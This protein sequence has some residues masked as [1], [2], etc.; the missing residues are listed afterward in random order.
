MSR[1]KTTIKITGMHCAVCGQTIEKALKRQTGVISANVNFATE[2]AS[3]EFD[4]DKIDVEKLE[5]TV[6]GT[7]YGVFEEE[8]EV[9]LKVS[10]MES[11]HCA[12]IVEKALRN[13]QGIQK[14]KLDF[15]S[16]RAEVRYNPDKITL[17]A[18]KD[19]IKKTGYECV[20]LKEAESIDREKLAREK[21]IRELR[22]KLIFGA[23]LS[24]VIFLGSFTELFPWVPEFLQNH[25]TLFILATPVQFWVGLQFY[26]GA[27][28]ALKNKTT[29]MNTLIAVGSSAAYLYSAAVALFPSFFISRGIGTSIYF[30]T[31]AFIIT[32][33]ILGRYFE[34]LARGRTSEAIKNL[35][36]LR[37]KTALVLRDGK[38]V[39]I[40]AEDVQ[41]GDLLVVRPGEK[42]PVDGVVTAGYSGVDEK[43]ITGESIPVE[44][45]K[46]D[47]V[48]GATIN[49]TG[50]LK[51]K[52]T[53]VGKDTV[54]A[55]IIRIVEEAQ[56]S[57]APIQRMADLIASYFVPSVI[58]IAV[59]SFLTWYFLVGMSFLFTLTIFIA[60][61]IIACP[62]AMGLATPTAIMVGTG[63]GAENGILIKSGEA[64]ERAH[65]IQSV[66]FDKTGTLTKGEPSVTDIITLGSTE[67]DVL[68]L[69]AIAEKGS[70]HPIGEAIVRGA[71]VQK[72]EI[73]D[74]SG[75]ETVAGKGIRAMY[76]NQKILV[77]NRTFMK[78][79]KID[80]GPLENQ[81]KKLEEAG[82]TSVIVAVN[83]KVLGMIAVA[84]TITE[85][86]KE[87][88][89]ELHRMK[90]EVI[91]IT[92]D[93]EM[94][95]KA[96][97]GQLGI[98]RVLAQVL[99]G[100]K[101]KEIKKLQEEGKVVA[102]VG[103]GINDAPALTQADVGI[104]IGSGTDIA[105]ESGNIVLIKNDVRDVV[106]AIDLSK[107]TI[108]KIRQN[109][110]WAFF[111]NSA[112]I[113]IAAGILYPFFN[114]LLSPVIA[115]GVMA[116]SSV[117]VVG[118]SLLMKRY[119]S[120]I[121]QGGM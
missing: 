50:L 74:A 104:A 100:E 105:M 86:A 91:M 89:E 101:A 64:L 37:A 42:I 35:V 52:A 72:I 39:E 98:D 22:I 44:K 109:L 103:D 69:A 61:L 112:G 20:E 46:G 117:S 73:P 59:A 9:L 116:F 25:T 4:P 87:A 84:D 53:N 62:C 3:V 8:G 38:E 47:K 14:V 33:I 78:E 43:V 99:P 55:Q 76:S 119:K 120:K 29:D 60:V 13:T 110:F 41:V 6:R 92:G 40:P 45:R 115:A 114:F 68:K 15:S 83:Q 57:K 106:T 97:A 121:G 19:A 31:A 67:K 12:E 82:K 77:G 85:Y 2:K 56:A 30:D 5:D 65:K 49:K 66:V 51:F 63:K 90:K 1:K 48:I 88:V 36:G 95:A 118:N 111:Y 10:G 96:I 16:E 94:T 80:Y 18:I 70:E 93:N 21:Q 28:I 17:Q 26:R 11:P 75:Y 27:W 79:N 102:M 58:L 113:P 34:A 7:G 54:L 107:Y 23:V 81:V 108:K 32:L 71:E 24:A